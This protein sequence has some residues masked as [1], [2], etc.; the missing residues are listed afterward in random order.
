MTLDFADTSTATLVCSTLALPVFLIADQA[1][2][3]T[4]APVKCSGDFGCVAQSFNNL[5]AFGCCNDFVCQGLAVTCVDAFTNMCTTQ[6][7]YCNLYSTSI[8]S[9]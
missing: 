7:I 1:N 8:L 2:S 9:W 6:S 4:A 3:H 5:P